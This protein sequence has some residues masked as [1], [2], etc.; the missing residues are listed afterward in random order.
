MA[1]PLEENTDS[2]P[3]PELDR[4]CCASDSTVLGRATLKVL[5][6]INSYIQGQRACEMLILLADEIVC[7]SRSNFSKLGMAW[8]PLPS[9][10]CGW[11][12]VS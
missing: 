4:V 12:G 9:A 3:E 1:A 7:C 8:G 10:T 11:M 2:T 5:L 6:L